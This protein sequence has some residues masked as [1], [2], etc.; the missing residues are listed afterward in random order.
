MSTSRDN[1]NVLGDFE[2]FQPVRIV[3]DFSRVMNFIPVKSLDN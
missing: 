1:L 2:Y 3:V